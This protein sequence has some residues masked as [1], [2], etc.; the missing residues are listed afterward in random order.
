MN[1][2]EDVNRDKFRVIDLNGEPWFVLNEVCDKLGIANPS[3]AAGRLDADE[4]SA[5][6]ITDPH[7]R[8]QKTT[9]INESGLF[10][11][12]LTS[13]KPEAKAFKKWVTSE[14]LPAPSAPSAPCSLSAS[15]R[16]ANAGP[17][18]PAHSQR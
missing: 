9:V 18:H 14:V 3:D 2:F 11:L 12:I 4:K 8:S 15:P 17:A 5:L 1:I 10:S 7:G 13:R 6:G 16:S